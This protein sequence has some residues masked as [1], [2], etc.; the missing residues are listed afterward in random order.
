M[1]YLLTIHCENQ[2]GIVSENEFELDTLVDVT[3]ILLTFVP[4]R[5]YETF[6]YS[7]DK[8]PVLV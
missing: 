4:K 7:I 1:K 3:R 5:G 6:H 8:I 2:V